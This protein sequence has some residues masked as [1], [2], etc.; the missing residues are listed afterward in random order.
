[1]LSTSLLI[2]SAGRYS[3][4]G[5]EIIPDSIDVII[6]K[7]LLEISLAYGFLLMKDGKW[8]FGA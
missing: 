4:A 8:I 3:C 5:A 6:R 7:H 1:M 2:F